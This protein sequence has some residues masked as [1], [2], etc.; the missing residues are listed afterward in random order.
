MNGT[1]FQVTAISPSQ[2]LSTSGSDYITVTGTGFSAPMTGKTAQQVAT[3]VILSSGGTTG[4]WQ[5]PMGIG[6][7]VQ[8]SFVS[9]GHTSNT[10][11]DYGAPTVTSLSPALI[12]QGAASSIIVTGTNLGYPG[13]TAS[14]FGC[15]LIT[16]QSTPASSIVG[17]TTVLVEIGVQSSA[18]SPKAF[19]AT[20]GPRTVVVPS[21]VKFEV[22]S[23]SVAG[24]KKVQLSVQNYVEA[25]F[26]AD[27]AT[28]AGVSSPDQIFIVSVTAAGAGF[29]MFHVQ[30]YDLRAAS[31]VQFIVLPTAAQPDAETSGLANV[32][33]AAKD[34]SLASKFPSATGLVVDSK[35]VT[36]DSNPASAEPEG[37][38]SKGWIAAVAVTATF[39]FLSIVV[40]VYRSMQGQGAPK[41]SMEPTFKS[42]VV[43]EP[44]KDGEGSSGSGSGSIF[45]KMRS[46]VKNPFRK[47]AP[48]DA[49]KT[50][51]PAS[52]P[53]GGAPMQEL[54]VV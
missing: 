16:G 32:E 24:A 11:F 5:V 40:V 23:S 33:K 49:Q 27:M 7:G 46:R 37:K 22:S 12:P 8:I 43:G 48:A 10:T 13:L 28:I 47:S 34:G 9:G 29:E 19:T 50:A 25:T 20:L 39:A 6:M 15:S 3:P 53:A 36:I 45:S 14:K 30:E 31:T 2:G 4:L 21:T 52:A 26:K 51:D 54:R 1:V 18:Q 41:E 38:V 17:D 35:T 44:P 42:P